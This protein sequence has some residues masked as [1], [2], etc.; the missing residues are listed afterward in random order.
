MIASALDVE[1]DGTSKSLLGRASILLV[2]AGRYLAQFEEPLGTFDTI[3]VRLK[4]RGR[5]IVTCVERARGNSV[6]VQLLE[7][8]ESDDD[9]LAVGSDGKLTW[10]RRVV[11]A[12]CGFELVVVRS[13]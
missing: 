8:V 11:P 10:C 7:Q 9:S 13:L 12:S 3:V 4:D 1:A 2:H 5:R 6:D